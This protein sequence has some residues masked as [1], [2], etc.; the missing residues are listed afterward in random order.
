V[1]VSD[2]AVRRG[3]TVLTLAVYGFLYFPMVVIAIFSFAKNPVSSLP[4]QGFTLSWYREALHDADII[5][6]VRNSVVVATVAVAIAVTFGVPGALL[7]DRYDFPGKRV[8]QKFVVLPLI[9]P[10]V[11]TGV[12]FLSFYTALGIHLSLWTVM[13]GHGT[14][15]ISTVLTTV[16]ARLLRMDRSIEDASMDL[17]AS[18]WRTFWKIVFPN[19]RTAILAAALLSFTLSMDEIPVTFFIIGRQNTLP[20]AIWSM[21]RRGFTPEINAVSTVILLMGITAV[22]LFSYLTEGRYKPEFGLGGAPGQR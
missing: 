20:M 8:F 21:L 9:L 10:G 14:A 19:I 17:G 13:L 18:R 7:V 11:I 4:V 16:Y 1:A 6:A 5:S 3:L 12:S 22:T 2:R 15:L